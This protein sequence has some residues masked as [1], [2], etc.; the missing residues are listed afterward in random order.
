MLNFMQDSAMR[1]TITI[2]DE[3]FERAVALSDAGLDKPSEVI[4]EAMMTY[5]RIQSARRL[6]ALG[7]AAPEM[8][9]IPRRSTP[10]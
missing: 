5:V 6:A 7:G 10:E 9:D 4:R 3:L 2:D 8:A 1:A